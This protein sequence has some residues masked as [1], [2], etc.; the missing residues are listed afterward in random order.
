MPRRL[1][2]RIPPRQSSSP[3]PRADA[4][5]GPVTGATPHERLRSSSATPSPHRS[6]PF[7]GLDRAVGLDR[8]RS[9]WARHEIGPA[10]HA[11][12][13]CRRARSSGPLRDDERAPHAAD[14]FPCSRPQSSRSK[15]AKARGAGLRRTPIRKRRAWPKR[16]QV[17]KPW[18]LSWSFPFF[19]AAPVLKASR[20]REFA[21]LSCST[22]ET[23]PH[24]RR[25]NTHRDNETGPRESC[26]SG[27]VQIA[28]RSSEGFTFHSHSARRSGHPSAN[29]AHIV[30]ALGRD[31]SLETSQDAAS[32][33]ALLRSC[34]FDGSGSRNDAWRTRGAG[35]EATGRR[36][37]PG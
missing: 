14:G 26:T 35:G 25:N 29:R 37:S 12:G 13:D 34:R 3:G 9:A 21:A 31:S 18:M 27:R 16:Q 11:A 1:S 2:M 23:H 36:E 8:P 22:N 33:T 4:L 20:S 15:R 24:S 28:T 32:S 17:L 30:G 7:P 6:G 10:P 5:I 19:E